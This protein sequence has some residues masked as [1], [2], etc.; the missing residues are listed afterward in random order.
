MEVI[1]PSEYTN[2][3]F[4]LPN[5]Q[6]IVRIP[7][8]ELECGKV[9]K[10]PQVAFK[11]F[12]KLNET[13]D[14]VLVI[15]HALSGSCDVEDWWGS[16]LGPGKPFDPTIFF[17][18]CGNVLGSPYGSASPITINPDTG[19]R[20]GPSFPLTTLRDDVRIHKYILDQLKVKS[21][22][23][24]IGGS[25]GGMQ[26]LEWAFFGKDYVHNII[27][28]ATSS[29]Q[30][31]WGISWNEA[32][33]QAIFCVLTIKMVFILMISLHILVYQMLVFKPY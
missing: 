16:L 14:N 21:V 20:Y 32:Q 3:L 24:V 26:A 10:N 23:Y 1:D 17:I 4:H 9:L 22:E 31:A 8:F 11:T 30:S 12:G 18:F 13:R 28:I 27:A 2:P 5:N 19:H 6:T 25:L 29:Y 33:R 15:C 7:D